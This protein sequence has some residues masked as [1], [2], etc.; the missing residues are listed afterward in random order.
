VERNSEAET[1]RE[2]TPGSWFARPATTEPAKPAPA[3]EAVASDAAAAESDMDVDAAP[4][5]VA[6]RGAADAA[7]VAA[8]AAPLATTASDSEPEAEAAPAPEAA[9]AAATDAAPATTDAV[10]ET[11]AP[12]APA[13]VDPRRPAEP[14][15][16]PAAGVAAAP[17]DPRRP[18][19]PEPAVGDASAPADSTEHAGPGDVPAAPPVA[20][21]RARPLDSPTT[22]LRM[23]L[24]LPTRTLRQPD[25]A[26]NHEDS[27]PDGEPAAAAAAPAAAAASARAEAPAPAPAPAADAAPR[28][29]TPAVEPEV[30]PEPTLL[31]TPLPTQPS[32]EQT[33]R[34]A[35]VPSHDQFPQD[36]FRSEGSERGAAAATAATAAATAERSAPAQPISPSPETTSEAMDVLA[37]L[38]R[39][40]VTPFRRA[41]KR[42]SLWGGLLCVILAILAVIQVLRPV[43]ATKLRMTAAS[44]FS[45]DGSGPAITWPASG[46]ATAE[47][48]GLGSLGHI[49]TDNPVPI[50]SVTK[51]MT[52]HLV[53][54]DH[55]LKAGDPGP[56]ITVDQ[57]AATEYTTGLAQGESVAKVTAG[58][59]ITEYQALQMLLIP[60]A[61]NIARLLGRWDAG[62]DP[63]FVTK[64][65]AEA[66]ALGMSNSTYTDPSG[67]L[68][69]TRSTANDQLKL[70]ATVMQ[71]PVFREIVSTGSFTPPGGALTY[72]NNALL[73]KN[74][75]IGIKTGSSSAALGCLMWAAEK[76]IGGTT[77]LVLGVVLSQ[78]ASKATGGYLPTVLANS[79]K[80]VVSAEGALTSHVIAK[81]GDVVGYVDDGLGGRTPV[82]VSQDVSVVGWSGLAV[83]VALDPIA[84]GVPHTGTAGATVGTLTVG[85]GANAQRIPVALQSDLA[86]PSYQSRL[87]RLG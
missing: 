40:Q 75:V 73:N 66:T 58:E 32:W 24:D 22:A 43:P 69:T 35:H 47:V 26:R 20:E 18:A 37:T 74:G 14:K 49:G 81:K 17:V 15:P 21:E 65:Q 28:T 53:L 4:G 3:Q 13:P 8:E 79:E 29:V 7:P 10:A 83:A 82:V 31:S 76:K 60:S 46:Q 45:F 19:A 33:Q 85:S 77:Q 39:R 11:A 54:K 25:T 86:A 1:D 59:Q 9:P 67:L 41:V 78:P 6:A 64:M 55:P 80:V 48:A 36:F 44:S 52:A 57:T 63:A 12:V 51:V 71:D 27:E 62:T 61:N 84:A 72:N 5:T 30:T 38:S 50:A 16:E 68:G 42:I 87:T 2:K 34:V 56:M 23:P 70:A